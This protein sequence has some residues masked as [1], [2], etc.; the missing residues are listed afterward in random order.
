VTGVAGYIPLDQRSEE[1]RRKR[2]QQSGWRG[3]MLR[4]RGNRL[5]RR[6]GITRRKEP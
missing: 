1:I 2:K 6:R 5:A 3:H 4:M